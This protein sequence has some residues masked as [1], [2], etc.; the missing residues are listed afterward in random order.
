MPTPARSAPSV[1]AVD[2]V[3]SVQENPLNERKGRNGRMRRTLLL[4]AAL[5]I[6]C[7]H[8]AATPLAPARAE[9]EHCWWTVLR[10]DLPPDTVAAH[11]ARTYTRAGLGGATWAHLADTAWAHAGP[12]ELGGARGG[13][14]YEARVVAYRQG[15]STSFRHYTSITPPAGGWAPPLDSVQ[16]PAGGHVGFCGEIGRAALV[17]GISPQR[18]PNAEDSLPVFRP[19]P[20]RR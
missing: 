18:L 11:F 10:T 16:G 8:P 1:C 9:E 19:R 2:F 6:G 5:S 15:D 13:G 3:H 12:T 20:S 14:T 7:H 4:S 17:H